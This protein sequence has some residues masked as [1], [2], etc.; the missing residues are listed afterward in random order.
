MEDTTRGRAWEGPV[1]VSLLAP[2][3]LRMNGRGSRQ[4]P[5]FSAPKGLNLPTC[6]RL[7]TTPWGA[8]GVPAPSRATLS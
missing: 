7:L 3:P 6:G 8:H 1:Y 4:S 5:Y 2:V